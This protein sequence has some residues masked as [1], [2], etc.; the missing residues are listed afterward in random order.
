MIIQFNTDKTINGDEKHRAPFIAMIADELERFS[1]HVSRIEAHL[2]DQ[3]GKKEGFDDIRCLL[4]ARIEG[5]SPIA[6]SHQANTA[7]QAVAGAVDKLKASL[8]SITGRL[9]NH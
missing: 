6:V 9:T 3:N 1:P 4:E 8:I 2:T 7:E 5:R